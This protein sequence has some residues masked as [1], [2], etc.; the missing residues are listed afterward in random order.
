MQREVCSGPQTS[1]GKLP[2]AGEHRGLVSHVFFCHNQSP[3]SK[4]VCDTCSSSVLSGRQY[5]KD[6]LVDGQSHL[7]IIREETE[8]PDA[9]VG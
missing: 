3:I 6:V 4:N 7:L 9:Q 2:A 5:I 8:L 1:D